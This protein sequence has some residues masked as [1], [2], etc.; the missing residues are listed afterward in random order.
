MNHFHQTSRESHFARSL[1]VSLPIPD[2]RISMINNKL[3]RTVDGK[4]QVKQI[5]NEDHR[6]EILEKY[7][8]MDMVYLV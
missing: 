8:Y 4:K 7:F 6:N 1:I 3:I 5:M 2:G